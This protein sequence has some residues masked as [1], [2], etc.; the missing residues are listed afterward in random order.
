MSYTPLMNTSVRAGR[1]R[2]MDLESLDSFILDLKVFEVTR[3]KILKCLWDFTTFED[4]LSSSHICDWMS[5]SGL[6]IYSGKC[7]K[8]GRTR[9][10]PSLLSGNQIFQSQQANPCSVS[11]N[12]DQKVVVS[13][14]P[15]NAASHNFPKHCT[16][17]Q[18]SGS[19]PRKF[20]ISDSAYVVCA[21]YS[22]RS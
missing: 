15:L 8:A 11:P 18:I 5:G 4:Q 10:Y 17:S 21:C 1:H 12:Q 19:V 2:S 6:S 20:F 22:S 13:S 7:S 16:S 9:E 14:K 3:T